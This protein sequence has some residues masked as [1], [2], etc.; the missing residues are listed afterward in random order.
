MTWAPFQSKLTSPKR[1]NSWRRCTRVKRTPALSNVW[2]LSSSVSSYFH[3]NLYFWL[4]GDDICI[5][6]DHL[7][8]L[9]GNLGSHLGQLD[10]EILAESR[11]RHT[12]WIRA[13]GSLGGE[14]VLV[15]SDWNPHWLLLGHDW[16]QKLKYFGCC[17]FQKAESTE[18][19]D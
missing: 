15:L 16:Q 3:I 10:H 19:F 13:A 8:F 18:S 14:L 11:Q 5:R 6:V 2:C 12:L 9:S 4:R 1:L 17:H 7:Q